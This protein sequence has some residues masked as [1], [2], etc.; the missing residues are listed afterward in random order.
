MAENKISLAGAGEKL[1]SFNQKEVNRKM[2]EGP[3]PDSRGGSGP[4]LQIFDGATMLKK[5]PL[6]EL[7]RWRRAGKLLGGETEGGAHE[8]R[9]RVHWFGNHGEMDGL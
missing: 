9:D 1:I 6:A 2:G 3:P 8:S 4:R 5:E 7:Q